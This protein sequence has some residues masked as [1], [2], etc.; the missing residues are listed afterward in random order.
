MSYLQTA[1][2]QCAAESKTT[3]SNN[4]FLK[5]FS[6]LDTGKQTSLLEQSE[7]QRQNLLTH[8][9]ENWDLPDGTCLSFIIYEPACSVVR[10]NRLYFLE[11]KLGLAIAGKQ[12]KHS[13]NGAV[14]NQCWKHQ[15]TKQPL[16][17]SKSLAEN[18]ITIRSFLSCAIPKEEKSCTIW[19]LLVVQ[20]YCNLN[21]LSALHV[22]LWHLC[23]AAPSVLG[24][25]PNVAPSIA[26]VF[27]MTQH[28]TWC[29]AWG[30]TEWEWLHC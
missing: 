27:Q 29:S 7:V 11:E 3:T 28:S 1:W 18:R 17:S 30:P 20:N 16:W 24:A 2:H 9:A 25:F 12:Q 4:T 14:E 5:K 10:R 13:F 22:G 23:G 8:Q 19:A 15:K 6:R 26:G 21:M